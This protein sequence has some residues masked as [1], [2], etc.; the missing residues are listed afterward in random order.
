[1]GTYINFLRLIYKLYAKEGDKMADDIE[2]TLL[3]KAKQ[4]NII[5]FEKLIISHEKTV[6]N[7]A[8]RMFNN[9]EDAKDIAQEVFIK[10]YKNLNKFDG[11][12]KISTWIHRITVNTC[13]DELR[14]RKGKETSSIDSLID[15]DDGEVQKQYTDNSFNP[16]QSLINKEDIEDLKNAINLLSENHKA[17]IVLRDIQ[18]LSYNEIS[19]I[20][21]ISLGTI[22][23]RISRA[24][25]QLKNII[26][27]NKE[28]SK[29]KKRLKNINDEGGY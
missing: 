26:M 19:E 2:K 1:M 13:I 15:L 7:I 24:R 4:G 20:T 12:C 27:N 16:E 9:E 22:K 8:Y 25:I 6:Y 18:G 5:A 21:Q 23:S 10:I 14:K 17:L 3:N 11:N 29:N 28:L